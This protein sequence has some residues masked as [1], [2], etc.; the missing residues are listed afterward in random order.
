MDAVLKSLVRHCLS[1]E[2]WGIR[3]NQRLCDDVVYLNEYQHFN[4]TGVYL[5]G[6]FYIGKSSTGIRKRIKQHCD[7]YDRGDALESFKIS[8]NKIF[9]ELGYFPKLPVLRLSENCLDECYWL[10]YFQK[11]GY[12][13]HQNQSC[14]KG[15]VNH[16]SVK[17]QISQLEKLGYI[18]ISP[19]TK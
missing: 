5:V 7:N 1:P 8:Y 13:R 2:L 17:T 16:K 11:M 9:K 15:F 12:C 3:S 18:V 19:K 4:F 10:E 14:A 6:N